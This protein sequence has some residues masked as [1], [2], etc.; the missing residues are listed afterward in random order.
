MFV[1][2][3]TLIKTLFV[4]ETWP[5]SGQNDLVDGHS[6]SD[7]DFIVNS[8]GL[9]DQNKL[10]KHLYGHGVMEQGHLT[11]SEIDLDRQGEVEAESRTK[12][13]H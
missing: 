5:T 2:A 7:F 3:S 9:R 4:R 11:Y 10:I 8:L 13:G 1:S 6:S 12:S